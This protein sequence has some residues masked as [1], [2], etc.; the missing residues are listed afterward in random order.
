MTSNALVATTPMGLQK[1]EALTFSIQQRPDFAIVQVK[2]EAGQQVL[3]EPS[4]MMSM[5]PSIELKAGFKGGLG[6]TLGRALGGESLIVSTYT[7]RAPGEVVF[8]A[9]PIGDISHYPLRGNTILLQR[10]AFVACSPGVQVTGSWQGAKGFFSGEGLVLLKA[11]GQGDL[12]F[13]SF[14][15]ILQIDV[16]GEYYVDTGF[17]VAFE[18]TLNYSVTVLPGMSTKGKVKSF[19][20]GGEGLVTKFS[21]QGK[22]WVQTRAVNPY[23]NWLTPFRPVQKSGS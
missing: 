8:A 3:S 10:G 4:V 17:I 12:F 11:S 18:D 14:G 7:A 20:F 19:F 16:S 21:G 6:K 1:G 5:D 23:L 22:V 2:L 13:N 9:G 15:A